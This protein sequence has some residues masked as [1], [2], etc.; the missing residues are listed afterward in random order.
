MNDQ[1]IRK[2]IAPIQ[3]S[4][5]SE[6]FTDQVMA[7]LDHEEQGS[8]T[9]D[10]LFHPFA[11]TLLMLVVITISS[12]ITVKINLEGRTITSQDQYSYTVY[13]VMGDLYEK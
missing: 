4:S 9:F 12:F 8:G 5:F 7:S 11:A 1:D 6:N 3:E 10:F 2:L 13:E